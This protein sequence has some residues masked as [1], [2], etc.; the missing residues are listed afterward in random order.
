MRARLARQEERGKEGRTL[1]LPAVEPLRELV[2]GALA[3]VVGER[4]LALVHDLD[5][6]RPE[7]VLEDLR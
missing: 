2:R 5:E 7:A 6:A 1:L 3:A 4:V